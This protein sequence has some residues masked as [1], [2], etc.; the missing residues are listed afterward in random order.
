MIASGIGATNAQ[1]HD[2]RF[3]PLPGLLPAVEV[4]LVTRR[5]LVFDPQLEI[6]KE[7]VRDSVLAMPWHSSVERLGRPT[8]GS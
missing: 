6:L 7:I 2:L 1:A 8:T 3:V 5:D 4:A